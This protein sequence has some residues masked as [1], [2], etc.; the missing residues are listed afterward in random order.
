[1]R[2]VNF[3]EE[4]VEKIVLA[5]VGLVCIWLL[6]TRVLF[7]PN[8]VSYDGKTMSPGEVD[9]YIYQRARSLEEQLNTDPK[10]KPPYVA[11]LDGPIDPNDAVR[12]GI[13]GALP[14]GYAGLMKSTL[15]GVIDTDLHPPLPHPTAFVRDTSGDY[16]LPEVGEVTDV[17]AEWMRAAAYV[18]KQDV[19][20]EL[21]Y[22]KAPHEPNDIDLVTVAAKFDVAELYE[23]FEENF[24]G[25]DVAPE[26][27]DPC[28]ARP[29]FAA[30]QL[31]RRELLEDGSVSDW[32]VVP[33]TR[34]DHR[35]RM[36]AIIEK[37]EDL[38]PGGM[39]VR[40]LQF[41]DPAVRMDLL[42][43]PAYQIASANEEWFPPSL[44]E[45]YIEQREKDKRE[46]KRREMEE[47]A[48]EKEEE[49]S[50]LRDERRSRTYGTRAGSTR[51]RGTYEGYGGTDSPYGGYGQY[52]GR[53][54]GRRP[55]RGRPGDAR[56]SGGYMADGGFGTSRGYRTDRGRA[57]GGRRT[58]DGRYPTRTGQL[59]PYD[60]AREGLGRDGT[61]AREPSVDDIYYEFRQ[62]IALNYRTDLSK[63]DE[64][65]LFWAHDDTVVPGKTYRY[66]IRLGVFNPTAGRKNN[67]VIL[68]SDYSDVTET[69]RIPARMYFFATDIK[70]DVKR[71][72]VQV[73]R[74]ALGYW[75]SK[76]FDVE[77]GEAIGT[78]V[79]SE[80]ARPEPVGMG[81]SRFGPDS[82][83]TLARPEDEFGEPDE[84]DYSTGAVLV[85]SAPVNDWA[86]GRNLRPRNYHEMLYSFDGA[87]IEHM[88]IKP[89]YWPSELLTAFQEI[90]RLQREPKEPLRAWNSQVGGR[91][92]RPAGLEGREDYSDEYYMMEEMERMGRY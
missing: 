36:F 27:R 9:P 91:T 2:I 75:Y 92:R 78:V 61:V 47:K 32:Q 19:T 57:A 59:D 15:S 38:P 16:A 49:R 62:K 44:H 43:P 71:V 7:S 10:P 77:R 79:E 60:M 34:I 21:P 81:G 53:E 85:D 33:R 6:F 40:L 80:T 26:L 64:P 73:A 14:N 82:I 12:E 56:T 42:Q 20:E 54:T 72:K 89:M 18:P 8:M 86:G 22:D 25:I 30:V 67:Q 88:P 51:T 41:D 1:M 5:I 48:R 17:E 46:E 29:V 37:V 76:D 3:L 39:K 84:I 74:Y 24:L 65:L 69:I 55:R 66:R 45:K 83:Y 68:W 87:Y 4:H 35:K 28:L 11:R 52:G 90:K 23:S 31:E 63:L 58:T 50:N 70:E 13:P